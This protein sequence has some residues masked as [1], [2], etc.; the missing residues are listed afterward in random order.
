[1]K[2]YSR[3]MIFVLVAALLTMAGHAWAE[4]PKERMQ[5]R[6]PVIV[7]LKA[8]GVVGEDSKGYLSFIKGASEKKDV[9]DAENQ[10]RKMVYEAIA[11]KQGTTVANVGQRRALQIAEKAAPGEWLQKAD[12]KWYQK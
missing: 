12:G 5:K 11:Q 10:D 2:R 8:K 4:G 7:D 6:L 3:L 1:M 9:V